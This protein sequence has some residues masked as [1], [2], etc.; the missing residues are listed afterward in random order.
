MTETPHVQMFTFTYTARLWCRMEINAQLMNECAGACLKA[1]KFQGFSQGQDSVNLRAFPQ[2]ASRWVL[3]GVTVTSDA[4]GLSSH[5]LIPPLCYYSCLVCCCH[6][7]L[8]WNK[9]SCNHPA[10]A[11]QEIEYRTS[12]RCNLNFHCNAL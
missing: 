5:R 7:L 1:H 2:T 10:F 6:Q 3:H 9:T 4:Q 8:R 11:D 12:M